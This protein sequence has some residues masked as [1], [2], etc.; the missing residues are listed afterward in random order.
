MKRF[1]VTGAVLC[2]AVVVVLQASAQ[3]KKGKTRLATTEQL[4]KGLVAANCGA[5]GEALKSAPADDEAWENLAAKAA[6][7][8]EASYILMDDGRCPDAVWA[9]AATKLRAGSAE[10]LAKLEAKDADG[11]KAAMKSM[12]QACGECH[13]AHKK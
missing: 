12:T 11:A 7:L 1:L 8:N 6:V 5:L 9:G 3:V 2:L 4:M 10:V 13:K